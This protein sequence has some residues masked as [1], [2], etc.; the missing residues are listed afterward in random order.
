MHFLIE[1]FLYAEAALQQ[2]TVA[3]PT[4]QPRIKRKKKQKLLG[5][6]TLK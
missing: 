5:L 2:R 4:R 1:L 3:R 6:H